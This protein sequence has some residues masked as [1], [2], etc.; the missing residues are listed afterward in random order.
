MVAFSQIYI[1]QC[2]HEILHGALVNCE[3]KILKHQS[4]NFVPP[5]CFVFR[6]LVQQQKYGVEALS[7]KLAGNASIKDPRFDKKFLPENK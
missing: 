7:L 5:K 3:K 2:Y 1:L 4:F 6:F